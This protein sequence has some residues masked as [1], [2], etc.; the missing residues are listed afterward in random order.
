MHFIRH[1]Q[2]T[3]SKRSE[4]LELLKSND[5][6]W[7]ADTKLQPWC[8]G[9]LSGCCWTQFNTPNVTDLANERLHL[10]C[11]IQQIV[12]SEKDNLNTH[13]SKVFTGLA[14]V[15]VAAGMEVARDGWNA[16]V[17][18][19]IFDKDVFKV[20]AP[21]GP[22]LH[23]DIVHL[24]CSGKGLVGLFW[25]EDSRR[26][27]GAAVWAGRRTKNRRFLRVVPTWILIACKIISVKMEEWF[28]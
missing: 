8:L 25:P 12:Q 27:R 6:I 26:Q 2:R 28:I 11:S 5:S 18:L 22:R 3:S 24:H 1:Q 15:L 20:V 21:H 10:H 4:K 14:L 7:S 19:A 9:C 16:Q 13:L 23:Q 17:Q